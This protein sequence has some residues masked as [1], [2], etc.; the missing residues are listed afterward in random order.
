MESVIGRYGIATLLMM[1]G[2]VAPAFSQHVLWQ[3]GKFDDSSQEFRSQGID[4]GDPRSNVIY[5]IGKSSDSDWPRFQPGP[6]NA[7]RVD[8]SI[9]GC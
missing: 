6:A 1:C 8:A 9:R 4:Y 5:T 7:M 3:I 2:L